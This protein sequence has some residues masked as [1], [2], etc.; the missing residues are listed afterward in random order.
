M[1]LS[2]DT[3]ASNQLVAA[4]RGAHWLVE[5]DFLAGTVR[6]TTAPINVTTITGVAYTGLGVH[7]DVAGVAESED[8][9]AQLITLGF[10]VLNTALLALALGNVEGYRG[11]PARLYL[12]LFDDAFRVVGAPKQRWSGYMEPVRIL[13]KSPGNGGKAG[14]RIEMPCSRAGVARSRNAL[15]LRLGDSQ[16]QFVYPGDKGYEYIPSLIEKPKPWLTK[17]FQE[18]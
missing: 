9:S 14:G 7:A 18:I 1:S 8:A 11:R 10:T 5:L 2:L 4:A 13:R 3:A 17:R 12:Q 6:Y 15:G 16:H